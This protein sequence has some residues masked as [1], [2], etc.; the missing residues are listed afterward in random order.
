[1]NK[2]N[3]KAQA[4]MEFLMTYGWA[5]LVV[6][7]AIGALAYFGVLKPQAFLPEQCVLVPGVA[8]LDFKVAPNETI[9]L[10]SNSLGKDM[11]ITNIAAGNCSQAFNQELKN[12]DQLEFT[13]LS[14]NNGALGEKFKEDLIIDY[15]SKDSGL[16]KT[17]RG[18]ISA[19]IQ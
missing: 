19:K 11:Q 15:T 3:K 1:V 12:G 18:T 7:A 6:L 14:C 16:E 8:C 10:L 17:I 9:L 2:L 5:I 13:L 4:A